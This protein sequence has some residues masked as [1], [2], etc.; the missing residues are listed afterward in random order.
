MNYKWVKVK[1]SLKEVS[2]AKLN[3]P[4]DQDILN[5]GVS[6]TESEIMGHTSEVAEANSPETH[7]S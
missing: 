7:H 4:V 6:I 3:N 5:T 2:E 1:K